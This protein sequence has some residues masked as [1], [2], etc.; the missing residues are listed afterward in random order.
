MGSR[1]ERSLGF[2][3][4]SLVGWVRPGEE[5]ARHMARTQDGNYGTVIVNEIPISSSVV[6]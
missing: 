1:E 3:G 5:E 6:Y 2:I 4:W